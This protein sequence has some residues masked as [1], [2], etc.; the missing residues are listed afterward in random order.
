[1]ATPSMDDELGRLEALLARVPPPP[2]APAPSSSSYDSER[3]AL[4][5]ALARRESQL[6]RATEALRAARER[7]AALSAA[8]ASG[9]HTADDLRGR[10]EAANHAA[11]RARTGS[12]LA[13]A[14]QRTAVERAEALRARVQELEAARSAAAEGVAGGAAASARA[15]AA[16]AAL[17]AAHRERDLLAAALDNARAE[18]R[19]DSLA[20]QRVADERGRVTAGLRADLNAATAAL[21][22]ATSAAA[23]ASSSPR[24]AGAGLGTPGVRRRSGPL[25][26]WGVDGGSGG[27][28]LG[29]PSSSSAHP[30]SAVVELVQLRLT[31][32]STSRRLAARDARVTE[33]EAEQEALLAANERLRRVAAAAATT[34]QEAPAALPCGSGGGSEEGVDVGGTEQ[35]AAPA[36]QVALWADVQRSDRALS[37]VRQLL[38]AVHRLLGAARVRGGGGPGTL[39]GSGS[40]TAAFRSIYQPPVDAARRFGAVAAAVA[41]AP[42]GLPLAAHHWVD[43]DAVASDARVAAG[44]LDALREEL[45]ESSAAAMGEACRTQ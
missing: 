15:A 27:D 13:T 10:L 45:L 31:V 21:A 30:A 18:A 19:R 1:M 4:R 37:D 41:A 34:A 2:A 12:E 9:A 36:L 25:S 11:E 43:A 23:S 14:A 33:L 44:Q 8:L 28:A 16:E 3:A 35:R 20:L 32:E 22:Q 6:R 5:A 39:G 29:S 7:E 42:G 26:P 24:N 40:D 38:L 17:E